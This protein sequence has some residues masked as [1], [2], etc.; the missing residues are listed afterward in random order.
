MK[1]LK[2]I[3]GVIIGVVIG[4][5]GG[6]FASVNFTTRGGVCDGEIGGSTP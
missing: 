3:L 4:L 5:V 2:Q 6:D 1:S